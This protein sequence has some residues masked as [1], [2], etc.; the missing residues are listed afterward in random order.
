MECLT[1]KSGFWEILSKIAIKHQNI[2]K[3][4]FKVIFCKM[5]EKCFKNPSLR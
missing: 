2:K 1:E 3:N 4:I 5:K